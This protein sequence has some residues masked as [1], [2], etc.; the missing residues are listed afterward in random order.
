MKLKV[1][2]LVRHKVIRRDDNINVYRIGIAIE[3]VEANPFLVD[4]WRV[5]WIPTKDHP[6]GF[7]GQLY[8]DHVKKQNLVVISS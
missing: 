8:V 4:C 1:G 2:S 5:A 6:V 7:N 3:E